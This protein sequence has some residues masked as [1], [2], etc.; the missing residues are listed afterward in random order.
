[1]FAEE[2]MNLVEL[3]N[4]KEKRRPTKHELSPIVLLKFKS[5]QCG[6]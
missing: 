3:C 1:M 2:V 4:G 6:M 5:M